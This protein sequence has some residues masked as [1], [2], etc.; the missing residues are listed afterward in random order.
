MGALIPERDLHTP[1]PA[2]LLAVAAISDGA[3]VGIGVGAGV[4]VGVGVGTGIDAPV[5]AKAWPEASTAEERVDGLWI[6]ARARDDITPVI[7]S[8]EGSSG[9]RTSQ[10]S[11]LHI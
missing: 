9:L 5:A 3:V 6:C 4:G 11:F 2:F 10:N 7:G 8:V 1:L